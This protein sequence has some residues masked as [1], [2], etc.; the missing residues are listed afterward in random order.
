MISGLLPDADCGSCIVL[1]EPFRHL[2]AVHED[3]PTL[4]CKW[5]EIGLSSCAVEK[6]PPAVLLIVDL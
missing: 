6:G 5:V 2:A 3:L 1:G 4:H